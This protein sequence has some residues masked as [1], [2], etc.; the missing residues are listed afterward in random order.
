MTD[1]D[2]LALSFEVRGPLRVVRDETVVDLGP[3][4]QQVV[5]AVLALRAR[6]PVGREQMIDAVWEMPPRNAVNLI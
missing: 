6:R 3:D 5:L 1:S 2:V 4:Q